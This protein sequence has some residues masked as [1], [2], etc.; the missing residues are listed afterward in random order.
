MIDQEMMKINQT[1]R[2]YAIFRLLAGGANVYDVY[3][4]VRKLYIADKEDFTEEDIKSEVDKCHALHLQ[5]GSG[6]PRRI[7][8]EVEAWLASNKS[9]NLVTGVVTV[10]IRDCYRDLNLNSSND[11]TSCRMAF[12]RL[13][14]KG[15]I[16][17]V[18]NRAGTYRSVNAVLESLDFINADTTPF[19]IKFPLGVHEFIQLYQKSLVVI[20]GEPNAGKGHPHGTPILTVNGWINI[21]DLAPGDR[22]F[23]SDGS[24]TELLRVFNRGAQQCYRFT[25]SDG[26][27]IEADEEHLWTVKTGYSKKHKT[28]GRGNLNASFGSYITISTHEIVD[29]CGLGVVP[30]NKKMNIP[31]TAP[32]NFPKQNVLIPPYLMGCLL[33]DA[34][35]E[36]RKRGNSFQRVVRFSTEDIQILENMGVKYNHLR[37]CNYQ[38]SGLTKPLVAMGLMGKKSYDKF[39]PENYLLNDVDTRLSILQGLMDT[40]GSI[41]RGC[42]EF[43]STSKRLADGVLFLVRS[44]GGRAT[45]RERFTKYKCHGEIHTGRKS[46]RISIKING[47]SLFKLKRKADRTKDFKKTHDRVLVKIE[48]TEIK[49]TICLSVSHPSGLY[50]AKDFI[51]THNTAYLLNTAWKN[52]DL[53]PSYF[54]SE[55]GAAELQVRLKKFPHPLSAWQRVKFYAKASDF[56]KVIVPDGLNIID[57]LE[58]S[59]DFYEIGGLLT[60]IFNSLGK[61]VAVVGIQKPPGRD[62]GVG[63]ART[64]DKARLYLS[65]VPGEIKI[66]KGKLWRNDQINPNGMFCRFKL[67]GG[68]NFVRDGEWRA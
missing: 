61:G 10:S 30:Q 64:L 1:H 60:D 32:V 40:D 38:L 57:Y 45:I 26:T 58:V 34:S 54:S 15:V 37:G 52:I 31:T 41:S 67:G 27:E 66:I 49:P 51:V 44:L 8:A 36:E 21:E 9:N 62:I 3:D 20:A 4:I 5:E 46:Y 56:P 14:E 28:T 48:K 6:G 12:K 43:C 7:Q 19:P 23:S 63:G 39:I 68:A 29:R 11:R 22:L 33:G 47:M 50:L 53:G 59:K 18:P 65:I 16:E 2:E 25:F 17:P 42:I 55:M 13:V 24:S 35:F